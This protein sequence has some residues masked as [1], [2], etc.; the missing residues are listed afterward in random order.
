[1]YVTLAQPACMPRIVP[2][3]RR[4][5]PRVRA[6][7]LHWLERARLTDGSP[8]SLID[9]SLRGAYFEVASRL[10]PGD[11]TELEL[12]GDQGRAVTA[13]RIVRSEI[14]QV[15]SDGIR[16]RGACVFAGPLPW[17][18]R[19]T[20]AETGDRE[21]VVLHGAERFQPWFGCSEIR[22]GFRHGRRLAGF[23]RAFEGSAEVIDVWPSPTASAREKQVVPLALLRTVHVV[24]DVHPGE[25]ALR[26]DSGD[27]ALQQVEVVFRNN[28]RICGGIAQFQKDRLGFWLV[29]VNQADAMRVFAISAAVA[30]IR[31]F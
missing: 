5:E 1:V 18:R 25:A 15:R 27:E 8:V 2:V 20:I 9:L 11:M 16:Y 10:R 29:P 26:L 12:V 6:D 28:E 17:T 24:R 13:G 23:T 31:V 3:N 21:A 19:L 14:A 30:E 22:L 4:T 7:D